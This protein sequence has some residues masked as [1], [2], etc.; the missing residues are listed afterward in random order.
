MT[1]KQPKS[2]VLPRMKLNL[3]RT[4]IQR[5]HPD[6]PNHP[7]PVLIAYTEDEEACPFVIINGEEKEG[8]IAARLSSLYLSKIEILKSKNIL[9]FLLEL[10]REHSR[11]NGDDSD[12]NLVE[13]A[14]FDSAVLWY[15]KLFI[16]SDPGRV[17]LDHTSIYKNTK[18]HLALHD[19]IIQLRHKS[20]AHQSLTFDVA[21]PFIALNPDESKKEVVEIYY[22]LISPGVFND[23]SLQ[24]MITMT[25]ITEKM[26]TSMIY[27]AEDRLLDALDDL[28]IDYLYS[29][30][31]KPN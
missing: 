29:R 28:G 23:Q 16:D 26:I 2:R 3:H 4:T 12:D 24:E 22:N 13:K 18:Q 8:K 25:E 21:I 1:R 5:D 10:K 31:A 30:S 9:Q 6:W 27:Y 11:G 7:V 19:K 14:F 20:F 15:A 17:K